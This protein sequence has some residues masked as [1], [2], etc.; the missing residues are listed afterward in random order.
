VGDLFAADAVWSGYGRA[1]ARGREAI[2]A[3]YLE[4]LDRITPTIRAASVV[5]DG[6]MC[7]V[8]I[9]HLDPAT[10][11]FLP[12]PVDHFTVDGQGLI[13]RF[14]VYAAPEQFA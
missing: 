13:S 11:Q 12:G 2:S 14:V 10:G 9:E 5:A 4:F 1:P 7:V 8:E 3:Y 6:E